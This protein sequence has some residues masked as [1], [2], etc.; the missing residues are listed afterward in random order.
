MTYTPEE[1]EDLKLACKGGV[2]QL[3][4]LEKIRLRFQRKKNRKDSDLP[5]SFS[6]YKA[7]EISNYAD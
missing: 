4:T 3:A 5:S 7:S 2:L 1:E 6:Q